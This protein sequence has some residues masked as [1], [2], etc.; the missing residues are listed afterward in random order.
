M[1]IHTGHGNFYFSRINGSW[2]QE[3][4]FSKLAPE[5]MRGQYFSAASLRF[6]LGRLLAPLSL[7]FSNYMSYSMTFILLGF[8]AVGSAAIYFVMFRRMR[9]VTS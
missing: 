6:T 2:N 9:E 5:N 3:S 8:F 4:F 7:I 1:G